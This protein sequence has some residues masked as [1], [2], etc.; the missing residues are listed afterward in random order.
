MT[1]GKAAS[2]AAHACLDSFLKSSEY[3]AR[4]FVEQGG[5]KVVL[6]GRNETM[7][8]CALAEAERRGLPCAL[9]VESGHVM[10]PAFDGTPIVT[11]V[12]IGPATRVQVQGITN[13]FQVYGRVVQSEST[14]SQDGDRT[15]APSLSHQDAGSSAVRAS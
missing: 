3:V 5:T 12:G 9:V 1:S 6:V 13:K 4:S 8:R 11:A 2:Q 7:L 15:V 14:P 10:P